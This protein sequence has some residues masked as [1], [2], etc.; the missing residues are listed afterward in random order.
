MELKIACLEHD[1]LFCTTYRGMPSLEVC[2]LWLS[3]VF[4]VTSQSNSGTIVTVTV[5]NDQWRS[6][7]VR[8]F[9]SL[10]VLAVCLQVSFLMSDYQKRQNA[11]RSPG[12]SG[13][14]THIMKLCMNTQLGSILSFFLLPY[15]NNLG[16]HI[17][18]LK[19][20]NKRM[21]AK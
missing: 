14:W 15:S 16:R 1:L 4:P 3:I 5:L 21:H 20:I 19:R 18:R 11:H 17:C 13:F 9:C 6:L 7:W 2:A 12:V 10:L 8:K